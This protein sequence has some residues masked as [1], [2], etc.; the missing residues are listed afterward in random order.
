MFRTSPLL[1][2]L[3]ASTA[4]AQSSQLAQPDAGAQPSREGPTRIDDAAAAEKLLGDHVFNLQWIDHPP[5][6]AHIT[7]K[8][9]GELFIDAGQ[10]NKKGEYA[11]VAGKI[12]RVTAKSFELDGTIVTRAD[13]INGGKACERN[14]RFTFRVTGKRKYW[15]LQQMNDCEGNHVVDYVDV[16]FARPEAK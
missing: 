10:R 3:F 13:A 7:K 6:V 5:G 1:V 2:V 9:D 8:G 14:G 4:L 11:S 15:R 16:F 12:L